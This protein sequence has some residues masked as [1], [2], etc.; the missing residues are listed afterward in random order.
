[1]WDYLETV[2]AFIHPESKV[3]ELSFIE[4]A[5]L[6]RKAQLK[7]H[8]R[9]SVLDSF[10]RDMLRCKCGIQMQYIDSYNPLKGKT[11]DRNYRQHCIDE[12]RILRIRRIPPA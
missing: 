11:N 10:N 3:L 9:T 7:H 1:M 8:W 6:F 12:M 5:A 2:S 4:R